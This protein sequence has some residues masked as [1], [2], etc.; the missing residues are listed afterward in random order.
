MNY[1][2]VTVYTYDSKGNLT[3][4]AAEGK[5][6][7]GTKTKYSSEYQYDSNGNLIKEIENELSDYGT[8]LKTVTTYSYKKLSKKVFDVTGI[9]LSG[10]QYKYDGKAKKP[11]VFFDDY[12]KGV[13]Y[14]VFYENN[15]KPGKAKAIITFIGD[16]EDKEPITILFNIKK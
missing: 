11:A 5:Y 13:D 2:E 16:Y 6:A 10:Y 15:V 12:L 8:N 14:K 7:D 1:K 9:R 3:K 4:E